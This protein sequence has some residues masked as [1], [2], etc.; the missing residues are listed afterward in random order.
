MVLE[1][2][3]LRAVHGFTLIRPIIAFLAFLI[4]PFAPHVV[5]PVRAAATP[6][7]RSGRAFPANSLKAPCIESSQI[8]IKPAPMPR[9]LQAELK[10]KDP[11]VR[12]D[13]ANQLGSQRIRPAVKPLLDLLWDGDAGV[14]EAAAFALGQI[15]D[16]LAVKSLRRVISDKDAGVRAAAAFGLGMAGDESTVEV[17]SDALGDPDSEVRGSAV[18]AL[19][20]MHDDGAVDQII[21]MLNDSS[22]DVRYDAVWALG[23]I[24][25]ADAVDPIRASL[26]GLDLVQSS[27]SARE[28]F[29][30]AAE[31]AI[32]SIQANAGGAPS[33]TSALTRPRRAGAAG[34]EPD[35]PKSRFP[36]VGQPVM[37]ARTEAAIHAG[38]NGPVS[39]K[40]MVSADGRAARIYVT[41]RA[42]FGLDRR[43]V[44]AASQYKFDPALRDGLPQS[45]WLSLDLQFPGK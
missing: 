18:F 34:D 32:Q 4:A 44:E 11:A 22:F 1:A 35:R 30:Q 7:T 14:R 43:A 37:P 27:D 20:L 13:A 16:P 25:A 10:S 42:G 39:L 6:G 5:A 41:H 21:E 8:A 29:K 12:R 38:V 9:N 33:H 26:S 45:E 36:S 15:A 2:I 24:G 17:L 23:Q 3:G 19:G 28:A 31:H 40:V